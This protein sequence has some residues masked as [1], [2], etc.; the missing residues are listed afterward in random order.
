MFRKITV[1]G[2]A[3]VLAVLA[4]GCALTQSGIE[5]SADQ[6]L[7]AQS[8]FTGL[9]ATPNTGG[10]FQDPL[11]QIANKVPEFGGMFRNEAGL[12][13]AYLTDTSK[14][15]KLQQAIDE[16]FGNNGVR[17][18]AE[19]IQVRQGQYS[20]A[21]LRDWQDRATAVLLQNR[22]LKGTYVYV[23]HMTNK[24]AIGVET[25]AVRAA[26][27]QRLAQEGISLDAVQIVES[28]PIVYEHADPI[29]GIPGQSLRDRVRSGLLG[30]IQISID[31]LFICTY[32]FNATQGLFN[33]TG[34]VGFVT[35][36]HCTFVRGGIAPAPSR[37]SQ[38]VGP[39][40]A[41]GVGLEALDPLPSCCFAGLTF[42]FS[43]SA[44]VRPYSLWPLQ[45]AQ[46][47]VARA[48][49]SP[50]PGTI[51]PL[52]TGTNTI[53]AAD[54]LGFQLPG[55]P[56]IR[57][58]RTS[59]EQAG[60]VTAILVNVLILAGPTG[61]DVLLAQTLANYIS[62][63]GDSGSPVF[64]RMTDPILA[65]FFPGAGPNDV[66]L[67][68]IHWGSTVPGFAPGIRIYSPYYGIE[69]DL[70]ILYTCDPPDTGLGFGC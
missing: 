4:G 70:G 42:R 62:A 33:F 17:G 56:V 19:N 43:D 45:R 12:L 24:L 9:A 7:Q 58:G 68:G 29:P 41:N 37:F 34:L 40:A 2:F 60:T 64:A 57:V 8:Q 14:Q 16:V 55:D 27:E 32:G 22:E 1:L 20:Y 63:G 54:F 3:L 11:A 23:D 30:G 15:G 49:A 52:I 50:P 59:G 69:A 66:V 44:Y 39:Y 53:R 26:L 48:L 5:K 65:P 25:L 18:L 6:A 35:N 13:V 28:G 51:P 38:P 47:H 31:D 21:Q 10:R 61:P 67:Y 36:S 46:G